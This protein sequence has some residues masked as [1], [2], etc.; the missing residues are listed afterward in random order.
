M[1]LVY[2]LAIFAMI[3]WVAKIASDVS[4]FREVNKGLEHD[5]RK[6]QEANLRFQKLIEKVEF[7]QIRSKQ[8]VDEFISILRDT[9]DVDRINELFNEAFGS[10]VNR[11]DMGSS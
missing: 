11:K 7:N 8:R 5:N 6:L 3:V 10:L 4:K 2:L 1:D 9:R